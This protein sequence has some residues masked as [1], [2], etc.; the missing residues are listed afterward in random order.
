MRCSEVRNRKQTPRRNTQK[1]AV[2]GTRLDSLSGRLPAGD[3]KRRKPRTTFPRALALEGAFLSLLTSALSFA[4]PGTP[5]ASLPPSPSPPSSYLSR[6]G[7]HRDE[8]IYSA[9]LVH[10]IFCTLYV[11]YT[12]WRAPPLCVAQ[13]PDNDGG[14]L[15][16]VLNIPPFLSSFTSFE[17]LCGLNTSL[18][19]LSLSSPSHLSPFS[20]SRYSPSNRISML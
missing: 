8:R 16:K 1:I 4:N 6:E 3:K 20:V 9:S 10:S 13:R 2:G 18:S 11:Y 12:R 15:C 7:K 5:T 17:D 19:S 14:A